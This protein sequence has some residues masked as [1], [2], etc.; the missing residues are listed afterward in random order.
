MYEKKI[1]E[2]LH[3]AKQ[4]GMRAREILLLSSSWIITDHQGQL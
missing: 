1:S 3:I 4:M 2:N